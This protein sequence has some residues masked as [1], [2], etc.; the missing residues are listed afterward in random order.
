MQAGTLTLTD[1]LWPRAGVWRRDALR[2]AALVVGFTAMLALMAQI[3]IPLPNTPVPITGQTFGVLLAGACLGSRRGAATTLLYLGVG[4]AGLPVF[5]DWSNG[6]VW[7][8]ATGGYIIGFVP[9][10]YVVG[11]LAERGWDRGPWLLVAMLLGN[12]A[13]YVPGL[14]QLS[15]IIDNDKV[16]AFGLYPFI[17]G[18]L[19]KLYLAS[20]ALPTAWAVTLKIQASVALPT[21]WGLILRLRSLEED[22][23]P[24]WRRSWGALAAA[25]GGLLSLVV[26]AMVVAAKME[27]GTY[28]ISNLA[29][30][31]WLWLVASVA[32]LAAG[33]HLLG[34]SR[35]TLR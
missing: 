30:G 33:L 24:E 20:L 15:F 27:V 8:F 4:S 16:L 21:T 9:A 18:D 23:S 22:R 34:R 17:P 14:Y 6:L 31:Y 12:V 5:S 11:W 3:R 35:Q 29:F 25:A 10:A 32:A 7:N 2:D 28:D 26:W 1:Y 13:L 19:I